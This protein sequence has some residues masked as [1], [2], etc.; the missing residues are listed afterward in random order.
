MGGLRSKAEVGV[1]VVTKADIVLGELGGS[2]E[3][4]EERPRRVAGT[5]IESSEASGPGKTVSGIGTN[6]KSRRKAEASRSPNLGHVHDI[7]DTSGI[8]VASTVVNTEISSLAGLEGEL[9]IR[10]DLKGGLQNTTTIGLE[11]SLVNVELGVGEFGA[12]FRGK[13]ASFA[14]LRLDGYSNG[15]GVLL[16]LERDLGGVVIVQEVC[17]SKRLDHKIVR[18]RILEKI[19]AKNRHKAFVASPST[20][21]APH[22]GFSIRKIRFFSV[23][24]ASR[25]N[26]IGK[27]HLPLAGFSIS[28]NLTGMVK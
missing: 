14:L 21:C 15:S 7:N 19:K 6:L 4:G 13:A 22:Q 2:S 11:L 23:Q 8:E 20:A 3:T 26:N 9:D 28:A 18:I 12:D 24:L 16:A 17:V 5:N 10:S 1:D 25:T 27:L